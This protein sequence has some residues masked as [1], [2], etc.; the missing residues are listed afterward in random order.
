M[1]TD[2]PEAW[3]KALQSLFD[4]L[5]ETESVGGNDGW[6]LNQQITVPTQSHDRRMFLIWLRSAVEKQVM[7]K[8]NPLFWS[9]L[10]MASPSRILLSKIRY[11]VRYRARLSTL[12]MS[13]L[14]DG[15]LCAKLC[16]QIHR[17]IGA[18]LFIQRS[19]DLQSILLAF[20]RR[21]VH[22]FLQKHPDSLYFPPAEDEAEDEAHD[23]DD[24][25]VL[26]QSIEIEV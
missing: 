18:S 6:K 7:T 16:D 23:T 19:Q 20:F 12:L 4:G 3:I 17:F 24:S 13:A 10:T 14:D 2:T 1:G 9:D 26:S 22:L 25:Q 8:L 11:L 5:V 21:Q 15:T